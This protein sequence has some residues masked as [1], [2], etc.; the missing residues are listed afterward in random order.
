MHGAGKTREKSI[1]QEFF[2]FYEG[3]F[4]KSIAHQQ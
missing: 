1:G 2:V 4:N 3:S